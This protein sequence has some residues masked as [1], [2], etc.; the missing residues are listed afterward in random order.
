MLSFVRCVLV[1]VYMFVC[2][3]PVHAQVYTHVRRPQFDVDNYLMI[4][5]PPH[6]VRQT[7]N[8]RV[9]LT[10]L[11]NLLG[12][13]MPSPSEAGITGRHSTHQTFYMVSGDSE[14]GSSH[15]RDE[16]FNH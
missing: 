3:W 2:M 12:G 9:R 8:S 6:S 4:V 10:T 1:S 7:Q 13:S 11:G 5:P 14:F 16:C 15:M